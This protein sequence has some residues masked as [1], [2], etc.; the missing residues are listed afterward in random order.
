MYVTTSCWNNKN[1]STK[2]VAQEP[3]HDKT[4]AF[5]LAFVFTTHHA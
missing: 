3:K 2:Y 4:L 5:V 1:T